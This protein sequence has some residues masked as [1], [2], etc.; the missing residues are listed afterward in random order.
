MAETSPLNHLHRRALLHGSG[1]GVGAL[2]MNS[3]LSPQLFGSIADAPTHHV[4]KAKSVIFLHMIGAPSQLDLFDYKPKLVQ[5][6]RKPAPKDFIEGK[7][8]AFLRGHPK[9]LGTPFR[10]A[11]HGD[12]GA[13]LSELLPNLAGV[14]D[15]IAFIKSMRTDEFNHAPAQM[16]FH[17]GLNRRGNPSLG[18][19]ANYGLGSPNENLPGYVVFISGSLPGGGSSLWGSGFLPSVYQ[20]VEFRSDG[21]PVLFLNNPDGVDAERRRDI[22]DGVQTLNR[23]RLDRFA[24]PEIATR[25][26]QYELAFR[27]QTS[28]PELMNLADEPAHVRDMYGKSEF[29]NHCLYAR[30]LV[31]RGVRFVELFN[32][33]WDTHRR[34]NK[35]LATKC[36]QVDQPVAA[37]L[38][39]LKQR[40][41]LDETLV[42][43][44]G[45]FGRTPMLQGAEAP[46][47][48]GRD[49]H[50]EAFTIFA[51]GG[52]IRG[53]VTHGATD[54]MGYHVT[55]N[56]VE[57]RDFH[58]TMLHLLGL[59]HTRVTFQFQG[60]DQRL[61][62]VEEAHVIDPL[63]A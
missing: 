13:S 19:W 38:T 6:D 40:G 63:L 32:Q 44:A 15:D 22:L 53:G 12:S 10:F 28:V 3:L 4:P 20:G 55:E 59:D 51:A 37:L 30:R 7:R 61:T 39:D 25:M 46:E 26:E 5:F 33:G 18:A 57:I 60:L 52:G 27:M 35:R 43:F 14:V 34:Q 29:A 47:K 56:P 48:A 2:A 31:E 8:F 54:E 41:L 21:E 1:L 24:D 62:G 36:G 23:Q 42:V 16:L 45:E 50:K 17:T 11:Q 49:H 9:L 58:A